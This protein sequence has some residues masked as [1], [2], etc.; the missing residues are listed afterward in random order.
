V[1]SGMD[2]RQAVTGKLST[3]LEHQPRTP[4]LFP[5]FQWLP[6]PRLAALPTHSNLPA[7]SPLHEWTCCLARSS[8]QRFLTGGREGDVHLAA[9][10]RA[11][12]C[13][14]RGG[15]WGLGAGSRARS[16]AGPAAV[17]SLLSAR[18]LCYCLRGRVAAEDRG[19][20]CASIYYSYLLILLTNPR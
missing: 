20:T 6:P 10:L 14:C 8:A 17:A 1:P 3:K 9:P 15:S 7:F 5:S 4:L 13:F 16:R 12:P 19:I 18:C 11:L 2:T